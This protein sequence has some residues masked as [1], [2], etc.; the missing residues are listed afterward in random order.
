[1]SQCD[2]RPGTGPAVF[3]SSRVRPSNSALVMR[4]SGRPVTS[5]GSSVSGSVAFRIVT[6][7]GG[8]RRRQPVAER[9]AARRERGKVFHPVSLRSRECVRAGSGRRVG[10]GFGRSLVKAARGLWAQPWEAGRLQAQ[11]DRPGCR[12]ELCLRE[13]RERRHLLGCS[14]IFRVNS[15]PGP[16]KCVL[17]SRT[18]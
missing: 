7:A 11:P 4:I 16:W 13:R 18:G 12:R 17:S 9:A 14:C 3:G 10:A 8:S 5:A 1:M 15:V 6:L 2:A